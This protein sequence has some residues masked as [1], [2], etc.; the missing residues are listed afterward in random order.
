MSL[1]LASRLGKRAA[2]AG[3]G[4]AW[5]FVNWAVPGSLLAGLPGVLAKRLRENAVDWCV[6]MTGHNDAMGGAGAEEMVRAAENALVECFMG[7]ARPLWVGPVPVKSAAEKD[8]EA[9]GATLEEFGRRLAEVC[10]ANGVAYLDFAGLVA[11]RG[12]EAGGWVAEGS[13]V[14]LTYGGMENLAGFV[15]WEG[16]KAG[17]MK[18]GR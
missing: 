10:A 2:G 9:Q 3:E 15:F 13:G 8:R 12:P 6:M 17:G 16:L 4:E 7:G 5:E 18:N 1:S 14:H 11:A